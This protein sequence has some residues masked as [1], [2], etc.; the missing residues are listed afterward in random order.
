[1]LRNLQNKSEETTLESVSLLWPR[2]Q[3][4]VRTEEWAGT[5]S[6][7]RS[8]SMELRGGNLTEMI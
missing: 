5:L 8:E 1:M 2:D 6:M 7:F 3:S 4:G